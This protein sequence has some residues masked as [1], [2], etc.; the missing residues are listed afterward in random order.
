MDSVSIVHLFWEEVWNAHDPE[1]VDRYVVDDF[2]IV[3]GGEMITGR[4]NFK[5]W[6]RGFLDS[7]V[8][9]RLEVSESFQNEDGSRVASRWVLTGRNN[10]ILGSQPDQRDVVL[11]GTAVWAV[12]E[13]GK[14][15]TNWV[16]RSSWEL[17]Q[18]LS[19]HA[20]P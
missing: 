15:T 10:G 6:I 14:L 2:V 3:S 13:D 9:L 7:V 17:S 1:A 18:R 4:E 16:E 12:R 5:D 19:A 8:D 20:A 11:T